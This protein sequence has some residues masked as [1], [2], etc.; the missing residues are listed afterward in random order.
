M[1]TLS[2]AYPKPQI[3]GTTRRTD[4]RLFVVSGDH[5]TD[6]G[7]PDPGDDHKRTV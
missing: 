5:N 4:P 2:P 6:A 1:K 3:L 7:R